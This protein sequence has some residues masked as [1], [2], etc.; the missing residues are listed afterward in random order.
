MKKFLIIFLSFLLLVFCSLTSFFIYDYKKQEMIQSNKTKQVKLEQQTKEKLEKEKQQALDKAIEEAKKNRKANW[1]ANAD[2]NG[3]IHNA[4]IVK[5]IEEK[6]NNDIK[7]A[8][9]RYK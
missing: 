1:D 6:Y 3:K 7:L 4:D 2:E 8:L 5:W 9:E